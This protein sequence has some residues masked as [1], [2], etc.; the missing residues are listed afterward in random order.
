MDLPLAKDL[1]PPPPLKTNKKTLIN[2]RDITYGGGG[3]KCAYA[4]FTP[5]EFLLGLFVLRG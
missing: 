1:T 4:K 3:V 2:V 5:S